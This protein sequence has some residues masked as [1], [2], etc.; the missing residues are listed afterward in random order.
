MKAAFLGITGSGKSTLLAAISGRKYSNTGAAQIEEVIAQVPDERL[1]WLY[2][3]YKPKKNVRAT[4]DCLDLPGLSFADDHTRAAARRLLG[5]VRTAELL[6]LVIRAHSGAGVKAEP[7]KDL[8]D[9]MT[10]LLLADLE[11]VEDIGEVSFHRLFA[12]KNPFA[13]FFIGQTL[14][15]QPENLHFASRSGDSQ[16]GG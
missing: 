10:E 16:A 8:S 3:L 2:N 13:D 5:N 1:D 15:H 12:D 14:S 4:I 6:A 7:L 11:L 9:L